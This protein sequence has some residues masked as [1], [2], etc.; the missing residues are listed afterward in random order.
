MVAIG[1]IGVLVGVPGAI[2]AIKQLA[3]ERSAD[4]ETI[5]LQL[6]NEPL[7]DSLPRLPDLSLHATTDDTQPEPV[8]SSR[9]S[10][11]VSAGRRD[12]SFA[13]RE[14]LR[15]RRSDARTRN[16]EA[17]GCGPSADDIVERLPDDAQIGRNHPCWCG[18]GLKFKKCHGA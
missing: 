13:R 18:S 16:D 17:I 6:E 10:G 7:S 3:R 5:S 4:A 2:V 11:S 8:P 9:Q 14:A 1:G 15:Q 12:R